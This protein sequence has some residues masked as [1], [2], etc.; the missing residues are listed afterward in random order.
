MQSAAPY[1]ISAGLDHAMTGVALPIV[2]CSLLSL[3]AARP[4]P[5]L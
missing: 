1:T 4:E 2:N 3:L 5:G